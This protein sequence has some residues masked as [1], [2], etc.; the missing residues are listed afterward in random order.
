MTILS[1]WTT[2]PAALR[3]NIRTV[4]RR[5]KGRR[6]SISVALDGVADKT[7][8]QLVSPP[9]LLTAGMFG[10]AMHRSRALHGLRVLA[11]LQTANAGL[12]LLLTA[13]SRSGSASALDQS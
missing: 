2:R 5:L 7:R 1:F 4:E 10:A 11:V 9:A 12:Q 8:E 3:A 13:T 6:N